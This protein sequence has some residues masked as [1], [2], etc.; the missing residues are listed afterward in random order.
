MKA[1]LRWDGKEVVDN[2]VLLSIVNNPIKPGQKAKFLFSV[3]NDAH[4]IVWKAL[5]LN[6][7]VLLEGEIEPFLVRR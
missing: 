5:D 2:E 7:S 6:G 3:D 1:K 4:L